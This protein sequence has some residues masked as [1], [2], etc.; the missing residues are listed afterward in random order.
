MCTRL[1]THDFHWIA[2]KVPKGMVPGGKKRATVQLR[3]RMEAVPAVISHDWNGAGLTIDLLEPVQGVAIGQVC[4]IYYLD[5][6]IGSGI[7]KQTWTADT[8]P[9]KRYRDIKQAKGHPEEYYG[10][11]ESGRLGVEEMEEDAE[12][13]GDELAASPQ[14]VTVYTEEAGSEGAGGSAIVDDRSS[15]SSVDH[16]ATLTTADEFWSSD[17]ATLVT[18]PNRPIPPATSPREAKIRPAFGNYAV[19]RTP[20]IKGFGAPRGYAPWTAFGSIVKELRQQVQNPPNEA[21]GLSAPVSEGWK[22]VR[23]S[24]RRKA[25]L[26]GETQRAEAASGQSGLSSVRSDVRPYAEGIKVRR[27]SKPGLPRGPAMELKERRNAQ[28][29]FGLAGSK[30]AL[31]DRPLAFEAREGIRQERAERRTEERGRYVEKRSSVPDWE[32]RGRKNPRRKSFGHDL[33]TESAGRA[34][35]WGRDR[36]EFGGGDRPARSGGFGMRGS[37][38]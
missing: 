1:H 35:G 6:C 29:G 5:W 31:E 16:A 9:V 20:H 36:G 8:H 19:S 12:G 17:E 28:R 14:P 25:A 34:R 22:A 30:I 37:G 13:E 15:A 33:A 11:E 24:E 2:G 26:S 38:Q 18:S 32:K 4:A 27:P 10:A 21:L 3:H 7:I 23:G